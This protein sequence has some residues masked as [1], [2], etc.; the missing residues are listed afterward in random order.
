MLKAAFFASCL[1][2]GVQALELQSST[3][4]YT[5]SESKEEIGVCD[6]FAQTG[7]DPRIKFKDW[8]VYAASDDEYSNEEISMDGYP[9]QVFKNN[10]D[11]DDE[12][13]TITFKGTIK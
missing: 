7:V 8:V 13:A 11:A 3:S 10:I 6:A 9:Y 1:A 4:A 2:C 12:K 5:P